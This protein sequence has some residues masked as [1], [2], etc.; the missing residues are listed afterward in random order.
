SSAGRRCERG[1][2]GRWVGRAEQSADRERDEDERDK[3]ED[4]NPRED[5]RVL[6]R[7]LAGFPRVRCWCHL[8]GFPA[9]PSLPN[10]LSATSRL[11]FAGSAKLTAGL[12][13]ALSGG[14]RTRLDASRPARGCVSTRRVDGT[15]NTAQGGFDALPNASRRG[16]RYGRT[17][18]RDH[19]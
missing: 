3:T 11:A 4:G 10:A 9:G 16:A 19:G 12:R 6:R 1:G 2:W 17:W 18:D 14:S 15:C 8:Q 5:D 7:R 13:A